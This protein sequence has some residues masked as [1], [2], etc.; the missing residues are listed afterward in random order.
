MSPRVVRLLTCLS[1]YCGLVALTLVGFSSGVVH[2][3][4]IGALHTRNLRTLGAFF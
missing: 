2:L 3:T 1:E 4:S